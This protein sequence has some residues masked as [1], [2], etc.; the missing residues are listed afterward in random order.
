MVT[1]R[2]FPAR[3]R[4][5][6]AWF[7]RF[8]V[9]ERHVGVV[10]ALVLVP[11]NGALA[12]LFAASYVLRVFA[13]EAVY[14]RYFAHRSYRTGRV[15]QFV[16][17]LVGTQCGQRGP[18]W[19]TGTHRLHH[20]YAETERDP[21]SPVTR[22]FWYAHLGW[23]VDPKY[24][25]THLDAV[26]DY[27]RYRELR[28]LD[29]Y[30]ILPYYGGALLLGLAGYFG[31]LGTQVPA[32]GAVLW[33]FYVPAFLANH[34]IAAVNTLGHS[35]RIFGGYRRYDTRDTSVNRPLLALATLG[36]GWHNNHHRCATAARAGFAWYEFDATYYVLCL[37]QA[38]RLIRDLKGKV[39][40]EVLREGYIRRP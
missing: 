16:L 30:F 33:G 19:W 35:P 13:A 34:A 28:W 2:S 26:A 32:A 15:V 27:A 10:V 24:V 17:A 11:L 40:R 4:G 36:M 21:H 3:Q 22:S 39:P 9:V 37:L 38:L 8:R 31:W 23:Y 25:D 7:T 5:E 6:P 1:T 14:H 18:L 12:V 29:R 20:R